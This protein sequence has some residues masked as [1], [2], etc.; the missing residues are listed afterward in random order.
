[1]LDN[2]DFEAMK[3]KVEN[4]PDSSLKWIQGYSDI[5]N[6]GFVFTLNFDVATIYGPN[7]KSFGM[8]NLHISQENSIRLMQKEEFIQNSYEKCEVFTGW[9]DENSVEE[10]PYEE[11][12]L[13]QPVKWINLNGEEKIEFSGRAIGGC[14]DSIKDLMGTK[15]DKVR[16]YIERYKADGIVWF[17][18]V[19]EANTPGLYRTLWQMKNAG[20]FEHCKGIIFGRPLMVRVDY[21][22]SFNQAIKD[23]MKDLNIPIIV[24]ADIGHIAPQIPIVNGAIL[25]VKSEGGK[26]YIKNRFIF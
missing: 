1:M 4:L 15:F 23:A 18:D 20:Y 21:D 26:G 25:E 3:K 17:F 8:R 2:L 10:D 22:L 13:I 11:Y 7:F 19:F 14:F 5:T 24:D 12:N 9:D 16:E 6:L